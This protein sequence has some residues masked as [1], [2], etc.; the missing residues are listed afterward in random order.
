MADATVAQAV[1]TKATEIFTSGDIIASIAATIALISAVFAWFG[2]KHTR[3]HNKLSVTPHLTYVA[4]IHPHQLFIKFRNS[5]IGPAK[6]ISLKVFFDNNFIEDDDCGWLHVSKELKTFDFNYTRSSSAPGD[7]FPEGHL[8]SL[9]TFV[10]RDDPKK[11]QEEQSRF[12]TALKKIKFE[13]RYESFY[14]EEQEPA[15]WDGSKRSDWPISD[16]P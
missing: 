11:V 8:A 3:D 14:G 4:D 5:G 6:I 10:P 7:C 9:I 2:Q 12:K 13:I 1:V 16:T 15:I